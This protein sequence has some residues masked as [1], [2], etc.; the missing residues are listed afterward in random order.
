MAASTLDDRLIVELY[1][2]GLTMEAIGRQLGVD[3]S[4]ISDHLRVLGIEVRKG[5]RGRIYRGPRCEVCD[6]PLE[7]DECPLCVFVA[8]HERRAQPAAEIIMRNPAYLR[9][10]RE[11]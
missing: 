7:N 6:A 2:S 11:R 3:K 5:G 4:T 9:V 8:E 1:Q 10:G